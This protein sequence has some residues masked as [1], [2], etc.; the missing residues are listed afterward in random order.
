M[1]GYDDLLELLRSRRSIRRFLDRPVARAEI[2]RLLEAARW[3]PSN[4]DRQPWKFLVIEDRQAIQAL[5]ESVGQG[6]AGKLR[7]LPSVAAAYAGELAGH[8]TFFRGAPLLMVALHKRPVSL[9]A[10]LLEGVNH[11][12]LVSGEPLSVAMAL[13]NL[14]LA[15]HALGLGACVMTAPLIAQEA[16][17]AALDLPAGFDVTCFVAVGHPAE[18]PEAPRRKSLEQIAEFRNDRHRSGSHHER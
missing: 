7:S 12:T 8:A 10:A 1:I 6:L 13:Q 17:I 18:C 16:V 4:H 15:A 14:L 5:A 3:A 9:S 11:P 2:E